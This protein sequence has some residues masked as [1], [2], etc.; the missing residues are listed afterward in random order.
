[1]GQLENENLSYGLPPAVAYGTFRNFLN[2]MKNGLPSR[3][4]RSVLQSLSGGSQGQLIAALR[5][6]DFID[7]QGRPSVPF[8]E[9]LRAEDTDRQKL[10]RQFVHHSYSFV[11]SV[12]FDLAKGTR[13]ELDEI[14]AAQ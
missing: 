10:I 1:M 4:D 11:F 8:S 5:Y 3:V 14:F 6:F 9:L 7:G 2:R 12:T 13:Q